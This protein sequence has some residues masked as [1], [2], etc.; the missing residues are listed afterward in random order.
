MENTR[1]ICKLDEMKD[2]MDLITKSKENELNRIKNDHEQL[3][4]RFEDK[5]DEHKK[6]TKDHH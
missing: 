2:E 1:L 5:V 4:S 6:L 3:V